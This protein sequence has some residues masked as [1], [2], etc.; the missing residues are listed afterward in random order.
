MYGNRTSEMD[1][2]KIVKQIRQILLQ[3][4]AGP[5]H[6][7]EYSKSVQETLYKMSNAVLAECPYVEAI[8]MSLPNIHHFEYNIERFN[9]VNNNEIL[10]RSEKPAGLIECTVRRGPRS[11]L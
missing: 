6:Q 1:F 10:F 11:R 2:K 3:T 8:T 5:P 9:L 4:L 7:G